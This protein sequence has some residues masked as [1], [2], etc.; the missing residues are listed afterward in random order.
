MI[1]LNGNLTLTLLLQTNATAIFLLELFKMKVH[2]SVQCG[3]GKLTHL[4]IILNSFHHS[5]FAKN[6]D[7][8]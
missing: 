4:N 2:I 3:P 8:C 6:K 7:I 5:F 1:K